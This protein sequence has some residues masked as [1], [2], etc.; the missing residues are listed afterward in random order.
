MLAHLEDI[1]CGPRYTPPHNP[2]TEA[3]AFSLLLLIYGFIS[4]SDK[5]FKPI[6][7]AI[8]VHIRRP[9]SKVS[10]RVLVRLLGSSKADMT[11]GPANYGSSPRG[12]GYLKALR[13]PCVAGF[14]SF[15]IT[16]DLVGSML[17]E[18]KLSLLLSSSPRY[19]LTSSSPRADI[20]GFCC[21]RVG[22]HK[23]SQGAGG[24]PHGR[25]PR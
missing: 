14:L 4:R 18:V 16:A 20:L 3:T 8:H 19:R 11:S 15:R 13:Q 6:S 23:T 5:L 12:V 9:I 22:G 7:K 2:D 10:Q 24:G 25:C 1:G 21:G 17:A